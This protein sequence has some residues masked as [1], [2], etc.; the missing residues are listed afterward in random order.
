MLGTVL[1][2]PRR[3]LALALLLSAGTASAQ[4][5][6]ATLPES[7]EAMI[8]SSRAED[9]VAAQD[10]TLAIRLIGSIM[11]MSGELVADEKLR[12]YAPV[13]R[14]GVQL[15]RN[16]PQPAADIYRQLFDAEVN[17]RF[18]AAQQTGNL[19]EI[20]ELFRRYPIASSWP[21]IARELA[22]LYLESGAY[23]DA[24]AVLREL[25]AFGGPASLETRAQRAVALALIGSRIEADRVL[26]SIESEAPGATPTQREM[27]SRVRRWL[28]QQGATTAGGVRPLLQG[29]SSW[30]TALRG[31]DGAQI[32]PPALVS[33]TVNS[34]RALP[35]IEGEVEGGLLLLRA[36][37]VLWALDELTMTRRW[38]VVEPI[39]GEVPSVGEWE[40]QVEP[41]LSENGLPAE[42]QALVRASLR[43]ALTAGLGMVFTVEPRVNLDIETAAIRNPL[44]MGVADIVIP[45]TLVARNT[46]DGAVAWRA[47]ADPADPLYGTSFQDAPLLLDER[48]FVVA[49]ARQ[50][51]VLLTLD[52]RNGR[53]LQRVGLVGPPL[54]LPPEGG[55]CQMVADETTVFVTTGNGV[56]AALERGTLAWKW[57]ATYNTENVRVPQWLMWGNMPDSVQP[58]E[59]SIDRPVLVADVLVVAPIDSSEFLALDRLDGRV[60]WR[61]ER[62]GQ[63]L[64]GAVNGGLL[65]GSGA[66]ACVEPADG[67]TV[68]WRSVPLD[69]TG[70]CA[71]DG[72]SVF[73]PTRRGV[74]AIDGRTGRLTAVQASRA[75]GMHEGEF[76][77]N[78]ALSDGALYALSPN[79]VECFPDPQIVQQR[80][81]ARLAAD[82]ADERAR[83][84]LAWLAALQRDYS[85]ALALLEQLAPT[86]PR[87]AAARDGLLAAT[88]VALSRDT[89]QADERLTWLKRAAALPAAEDVAANLSVLVGRT[90][91][92]NGRWEEALEHYQ[93]TL[94]RD[95]GANLVP[96]GEG[97]VAVAPWANAAARLTACAAKLSPEQQAAFYSEFARR[98]AGVKGIALLERAHRALSGRP[99]QSIVG[100]AIV[101]SGAAPELTV[102]YLRAMADETDPAM[103]RRLHLAR[104]EIHVALGLLEP[105]RVD[106]EIWQRDFATP[107]PSS[108]PVDPLDQD[109]DARRIRRI[110]FAQLKLEQLQEAPF[111]ENF[112]KIWDVGAELVLPGDIAQ[113]P[114]GGFVLVREAE[115]RRLTLLCSADGSRRRETTDGLDRWSGIS[116][117]LPHR[118]QLPIDGEPPAPPRTHWP[119]LVVGARAVVPFTG[120]LLCVGMGPERGG[121]QRIWERSAEWAEPSHALS[122]RLAGSAAGVAVLA[123]PNRVELLS[124]ADGRPRWAR[125]LPGPAIKQ[126]LMSA[127]S[128][129]AVT[130]E[131]HVVSIDAESGA[132]VTAWPVAGGTALRVMLIGEVLI[133]RNGES[134]AGYDPDSL[135]R[136]WAFP[137]QT[138]VC[139]PVIGRDWLLIRPNEDQWAVIDVQTGAVVS[140]PAVGAGE[141]V[142]CAAA[143]EQLLMVVLPGEGGNAR[144]MDQRVLAFHAADGSAAWSA[145]VEAAAPL[146]PTQLIG[147]PTLIP[148]LSVQTQD[149]RRAERDDTALIAISLIERQSGQLKPASSDGH[150]RVQRQ[151]AGC[152]PLLV[153]SPTR[154]LV[155][156]FGTTIALGNTTR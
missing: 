38:Q 44:Q 107:P 131:R 28:D 140:R 154:I 40:G 1:S 79:R 13:W 97:E 67:V 155:Q 90:L 49:R 113:R 25:E 55:R 130:E 144:G 59:A 43:H 23:A 127:R 69:L 71:T 29:A 60:R 50:E 91:E 119:A 102:D 6:A 145:K 51:L 4:N 89:S 92:E 73:A 112:Y 5:S 11:D 52:P 124:W 94:L 138:A 35:L 133:V 139:E 143:D 12:V 137:V 42:A 56:V 81:E 108:A 76:A 66:I 41:E 153:A 129:L 149:V 37:G 125:E 2:L 96:V 117:A 151:A 10:Y 32:L 148:V 101:L 18:E 128:V 9:A 78:L 135:E 64:L 103:R 77:A 156:A 147:H 34:Q 100:Q 104:W 110:E 123:G 15:L 87:M 122:E 68:R 115:P 63:L 31:V 24:L 111:D 120:G 16:L 152:A 85:G 7:N 8:L 48:L 136:K 86:E 61:G 46:E 142:V 65:L 21:T 93:A 146:N 118:A 109:E 62:K 95:G 106:R 134:V 114:P 116:P 30:S 72:V 132:R 74:L 105:A 17:A 27:L 54:L 75:D 84:A 126:V 82:S 19:G 14:R 53:E 47:G 58:R 141:R 80:C 26:R 150:A 83:L 36:R 88:F 57:A 22:A 121:G 33:K 39:Q 20:R 3:C 70:R 99:E 45:N 98:T